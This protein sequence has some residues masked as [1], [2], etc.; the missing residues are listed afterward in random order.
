MTLK[1]GDFEVLKGVEDLSV[2]AGPIYTL[3]FSH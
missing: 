3:L 2:T 1:R